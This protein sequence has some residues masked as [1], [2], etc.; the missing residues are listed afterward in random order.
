MTAQ[1]QGEGCADRKGSSK[2]VLR[3]ILNSGREGIHLLLLHCD[4]WA[5]ICKIGMWL[6]RVSRAWLSTIEV[7]GSNCCAF[8]TAMLWDRCRGLIGNMNEIVVYCGDVLINGWRERWDP[9]FV[10]MWRMAMVCNFRKAIEI[11]SPLAAKSVDFK[12][13]T[14][15]IIF[16][17]SR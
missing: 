7:M 8:A 5:R 17:K 3:V 2:G 13:K 6:E 11:V 15:W 12:C 16:K 9:R 14:F 10:A 4:R 1:Q